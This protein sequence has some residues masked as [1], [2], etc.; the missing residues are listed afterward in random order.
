[1]PESGTQW[2]QWFQG[3]VV[4]L[5]F[6]KKMQSV[7]TQP[8]THTHRE[9]QTFMHKHKYCAHNG[10]DPKSQTHRGCMNPQLHPQLAV[11]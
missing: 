2:E 3:K 8:Q 6:L 4:D 10:T 11:G 5:Y 7:V 9:T 1:M